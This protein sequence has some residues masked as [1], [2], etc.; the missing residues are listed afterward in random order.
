MSH[1]EIDSL[2]A[3]VTVWQSPSIHVA[4]CSMSWTCNI[5]KSLP[6]LWRNNPRL[7]HRT[8]PPN[9]FQY[10]VVGWF[11]FEAWFVQNSFNLLL[12]EVWNANGFDQTCIHQLFH[13]LKDKKS[14]ANFLLHLENGHRLWN[15][16]SASVRLWL[17][18]WGSGLFDSPPTSPGSE[19]HH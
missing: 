10:L 3:I 15:Q 14:H 18:A 16:D 19:Y 2:G 17:V 5:D 1:Y 4:Q 8:S 9:W 11:V 12:V 6:F 7:P 13:P